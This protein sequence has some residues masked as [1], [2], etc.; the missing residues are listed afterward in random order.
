MH[1]PPEPV[2]ALRPPGGRQA[3]V[4]ILLA[5]H[6]GERW[7]TEQVESIRRQTYPDWRLVVRD[8]ASSD[9]TLALAHELAD[10]DGRITVTARPTPSGSA[11]R[12]FLEL[13]AGSSGR[14][15]MLADQDDVWLEDKV[16]VTLARMRLLESR[17][18]DDVPA[19]VHTDLSVVDADLRVIEPSMVRSQMLDGAEMRLAA[20]ITQ[21]PVTGCTV[22]VNRALAD[23]VAPPFDGVA[24]HDWWLVVMAAAFGGVGYV[25]RP[26]VLYRQ[27][28]ANAVGARSARTLRY[29]FARALDRNGVESSLRA[30][31]AQ[32]EAF[33]SRYRELLNPEQAAMLEAAATMPNRGKLARLATLRRYGLWKNTLV[34]RVG[35][36][37]YG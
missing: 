3:D 37:L 27:H 12:S 16:E 34:K 26:T 22:M 9:G 31:Y 8:D 1:T 29:K 13:V 30:S 20:L 17:A 2:A 28:G 25:D 10:R 33:H 21:N 5:A 35:Q 24:M 18:G 14:Y 6:N 11:A 36:V 4:E 19:L 23:L 15:V 7:L 32:A